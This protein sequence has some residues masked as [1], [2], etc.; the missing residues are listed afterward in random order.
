[1]AKALVNKMPSYKSGGI[2][3]KTGPA[4]VH[5]GERV[6]PVKRKK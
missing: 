5:K 2:V 1:M 6:I 4:L 3:K